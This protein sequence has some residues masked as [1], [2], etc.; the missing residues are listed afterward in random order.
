MGLGAVLALLILMQTVWMLP[1]LDAPVETI[2]QGGAPA[3]SSLH[4][5]YV[6]VECAK[7]ALLATIASIT[8]RTIIRSVINQSVRLLERDAG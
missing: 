4:T 8:V 2:L 6:I 5:L 3:P 1:V 7:L